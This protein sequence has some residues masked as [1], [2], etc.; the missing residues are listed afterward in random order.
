M[1]Q[2]LQSKTNTITIGVEG[3][4][5]KSCV[6]N[7]EGNVGKMSGVSTV[8]V[9]LAEKRAVIE[10]DPSEV[11]PQELCTAIEDLGFEAKLSSSRAVGRVNIGINGMTCHSCVSLIESTVGELSGVVKVTVSL[12]KKEAEVEYDETL[13]RREDVTDAIEDTG[14]TVTYVTGESLVVTCFSIISC[15]WY[16]L[17]PVLFSITIIYS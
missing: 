11:S 4:V 10:Y 6:N 15:V 7:I 12:A 2:P 16:R 5:C 17:R 13:L 14:F 1:E 8:K 9:S 3:M